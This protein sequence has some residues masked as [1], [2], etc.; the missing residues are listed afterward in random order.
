MKIENLKIFGVCAAILFS[1]GV[2]GCCKNDNEKVF[3]NYK[4]SS[5]YEDNNFY[6][7]KFLEDRGLVSIDSIAYRNYES[8]YEAK[9]AVVESNS[10]GGL[11]FS[12][13]WRKIEDENNYFGIARK[14]SYSFKVYKIGYEEGKFV[15]TSSVFED[16]FCLPEEYSYISPDDFVIKNIGEEIYL[17]KGKVRERK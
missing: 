16:L 8:H 17:N 6:L 2:A 7:E 9:S 3:D 11:N 10:E 12:V 4:S 13:D 14:V 1:A 5:L 15:A